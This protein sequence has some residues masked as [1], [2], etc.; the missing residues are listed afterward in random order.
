LLLRHQ[1]QRCDDAANPDDLAE[2]NRRSDMLASMAEERMLPPFLARLGD[3]LSRTEV[4][5]KLRP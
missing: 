4:V 2:K 5:T 3:K 1:C